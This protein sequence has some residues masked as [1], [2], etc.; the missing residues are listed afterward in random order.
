MCG[1]PDPEAATAWF[2]KA[3]KL[4]H[5]FSQSF[6][7][8]ENRII[9]TLPCITD[10]V[11]PFPSTLERTFPGFPPSDHNLNLMFFWPSSP[12]SL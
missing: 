7:E 9:C 2:R 12:P 4:G 5:V 10:P 8:M 3:A 11:G 1:K 6:V